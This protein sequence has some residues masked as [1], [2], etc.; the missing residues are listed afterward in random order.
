MHAIYHGRPSLIKIEVV[1]KMG[2]GTSVNQNKG[3][4]ESPPF[5]QTHYHAL[6]GR[7]IDD[8]AL[9]RVFQATWLVASRCGHMPFG[10]KN[11]GGPI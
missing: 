1:F 7:M 3:E 5:S 11:K 4:P 6:A 2:L 9:S 8:G 10:G